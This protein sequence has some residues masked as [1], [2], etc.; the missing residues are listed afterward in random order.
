MNAQIGNLQNE[1]NIIEIQYVKK[2]YKQLI[3]PAIVKILIKFHL[4]TNDNTNDINF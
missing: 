3:L 4:Q 2:E 1:D